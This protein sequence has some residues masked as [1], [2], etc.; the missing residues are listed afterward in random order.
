MKKGKVNA[1]KRDGKQGQLWTLW[2]MTRGLLVELEEMAKISHVLQKRKW[3]AEL[4]PKNIVKA[5]KNKTRRN[6]TAI[7]R[8]TGELNTL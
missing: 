3:K 1:R 4:L 5:E 2:T 6:T 7:W 8:I